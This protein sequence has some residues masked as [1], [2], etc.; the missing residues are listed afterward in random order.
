MR[1]LG[2]SLTVSVTLLLLTAPGA[3]AHDGGEGLL[4][5]VSDKTVTDAGFIVIAFFPLFVLVMSLIQW[6][7]EKRK[8]ARKQAT[9]K[10]SGEWHSG[11]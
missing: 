1:R 2:L 10:L 4:G 5:N 3:F 6:R 9:K 8:D 11:W 7:L